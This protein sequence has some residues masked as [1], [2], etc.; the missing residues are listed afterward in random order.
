MTG[1]PSGVGRVERG[2]VLEG[3]IEGVGDLRVTVV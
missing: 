2:D 3:R 1:T